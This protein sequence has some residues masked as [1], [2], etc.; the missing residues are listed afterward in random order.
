MITTP[1][2]GL[3]VWNN[4][5]DYFNH[6]E[7]QAN[8][9]ALDEH[10]HT[11][12]KGVQLPEGSLAPDSITSDN[13]KD[14]SVTGNKLVDGSVSAD[15]L[16]GSVIT[17]TNL[18]A[19]AVTSAALADDAVGH[20]ELTTAVMEDLGL[21]E[22]STVRRGIFAKT[23]TDSRTNTSYGTLT[24]ADQVT[25]IVLPTNGLLHI[26]YQAS[27]EMDIVATVKAAIFLD[28]VQLKETSTPSAVVQEATLFG[29]TNLQAVH[30]VVGGLANVHDS[31]GDYTGDATTGQIL[32]PVTVFA[33]A[34]T[35]DVSIRFKG[36]GSSTVTVQNRKLLVWTTAF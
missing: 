14:N 34:G 11:S 5:S 13:L 26:A 23:G 10:D 32:Q 15:K 30:T 29:N 35:Y 2:M 18:S 9:E 28:G 3:T 8:F 17:S 21:S 4:L 36:S 25:D 6:S 33:N 7:L 12:G 16:S 1:N 22:A 27:W 31:V 24:A 20:E 19:N